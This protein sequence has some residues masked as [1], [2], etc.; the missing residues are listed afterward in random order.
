[1]RILVIHNRY[2]NPGGEDLVVDQESTLIA[3]HESVDTF[4]TNNKKGWAGFRQFLSYPF[5]RTIFRELDRKLAQF[6]P[7]IVHLHNLHYAIGPQLIRHLH[8]RGIPIVMTLHNYRLLCPSATLFHKGKLFTASINAVFPW[9]AIR[10]GV[11]QQSKLKTFWIAFTYYLHR[12]VGTWQKVDRYLV[13][14]PFAKD[15]F[16]HSALGIP[17]NKL[18]VKPNFIRD[19]M[20]DQEEPQREDFFLFV[21]RLSEEKGIRTLL[22]AFENSPY[23][24]HLAGD[25]PLRELVE[26]KST[27]QSNIHY[28]GQLDSTEIHKKMRACNALI[29]PSQWYEGMPMTLIE[30]FSTGTAVIAS[31]LGA[32]ATMIS[33]GRDGLLF[34]AGDAGDLKANLDLWEQS[35]TT[36]KNSIRLHA[37]KTY[38]AHYT[39]ETNKQLLLTIYR[40]LLTKA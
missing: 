2:Q 24:L 25:G 14:T 19:P 15:L 4:L 31:N 17:E 11:H 38:E 10:K 6:N 36:S 26:Q 37:R 20:K 35:D 32:M 30:A 40:D 21:G 39:A 27:E 28:L 12:Q 23:T 33:H 8:R 1:M 16:Q 3:Q 13:L 34:Q 22:G 7:D 5:N 9:E 29:F 18:L